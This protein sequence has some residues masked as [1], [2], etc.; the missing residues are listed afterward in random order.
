MLFDEGDEI[1]GRVSCQC[2]FAEITIPGEVV[3]CR[4]VDVG[5]IATSSPRDF[6]LL[7]EAFIVF[8]KKDSLSTIRRREG[9][10]HATST[11]AN[12]DDIILFGYLRAHQIV[13]TEGGCVGNKGKYK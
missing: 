4:G 9:A 12:H 11:T 1:P 2:R 8:Q 13:M 10:E 5:K 6:D 3:L 7:S